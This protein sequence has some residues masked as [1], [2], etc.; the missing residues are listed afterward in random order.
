MSAMC[1]A[2][3]NAS[4]IGKRIAFNTASDAV[5]EDVLITILATN[6]YVHLEMATVAPVSG[7]LGKGPFPSGFT[8][9]HKTWV[10]VQ[11]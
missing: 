3:L 9:E 2:D 10:E 11:G 5:I 1:A 6:E 4:H 8:V 7:H